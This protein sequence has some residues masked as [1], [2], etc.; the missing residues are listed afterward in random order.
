MVEVETEE[1][2]FIAKESAV[3]LLKVLVV[4]DMGDP[5]NKRFLGLLA[6]TYGNYAFGF[7]ELEAINARGAERNT[8]KADEWL[9]RAGRF[10][11]KGKDFGIA[12]LSAGGKKISDIPLD[13]FNAR[14]KKFSKKDVEPLFWTAFDWGSFIN[15][16]R[17]DIAVTADLPRVSALVDRVMELDPDFMCGIAH[18]F[19]GALLVANPF[20]TGSRPEV[21]K[22]HFEKA[23]A[24][25]D[26]NFL[27]SKVMYAE[28]YQKTVGDNSGFKKT[29][30]DVAGADASKYPRQRLANELAKERARALLKMER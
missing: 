8:A 25:C 27:M 5:T 22:P 28:W 26:G 17:D 3:P 12:A 7:A 13:K 30:E 23:V 1:D 18:A 16:N 20:L 19:K 21:A 2:V 6:K 11:E 4:L 9:A 29:L 15:M 10:Y 24:M 14:L